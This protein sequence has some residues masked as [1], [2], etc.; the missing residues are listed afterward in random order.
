MVSVILEIMTSNCMVI[1]IHIGLEILQTE[2]E[3]YDVILVWGY[4]RLHGKAGSNPVFLSARQKQSTLQHV[5]LV[6][7]P[8]GFVSC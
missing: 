8:Y 5:P 1:L 4:P 6:V 3:L 7:K 2:R